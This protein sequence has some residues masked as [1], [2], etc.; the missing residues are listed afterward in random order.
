MV[1]DLVLCNGIVECF[2]FFI[3]GKNEKKYVFLYKK[4]VMFFV[5]L[6]NY[7]Y[8][9]YFIYLVIVFF[10]FIFFYRNG[11]FKGWRKIWRGLGGDVLQLF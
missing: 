1:C 10:Y 4:I 9:V 6:Y 11:M 2:Q 5:I 7:M 8:I 3:Y